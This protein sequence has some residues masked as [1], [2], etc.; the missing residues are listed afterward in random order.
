MQRFEQLFQAI[1]FDDNKLLQKSKEEYNLTLYFLLTESGAVSMWKQSYDYCIN[2]NMTNIEESEFGC[3]NEYNYYCV[4][5]EL[6]TWLSKRFPFVKTNRIDFTEYNS[7][8]II[9]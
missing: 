2:M 7:E 6:V 3:V 1:N 5:L 9:H 8:N 4:Y